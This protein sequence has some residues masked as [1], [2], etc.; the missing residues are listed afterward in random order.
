MPHSDSSSIKD[1]LSSYKMCGSLI[2]FRCPV[3][4]GPPTSDPWSCSWG[5]PL[6][7][8]E[9]GIDSWGQVLLFFGPSPADGPGHFHHDRTLPTGSH[10]S[11]AAPWLDEIFL[12]LYLVSSCQIGGRPTSWSSFFLLLCYFPINLLHLKLI[13][14]PF[15]NLQLT[16][17]PPLICLAPTILHWY[18]SLSVSAFYFR[19]QNSSYSFLYVS[20]LTLWWYKTSIQYI[21]LKLLN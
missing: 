7:M 10:C 4:Q 18:M 3:T 20:N 9:W 12:G 21:F 13:M 15:Q 17:Y 1:S 8:T 19:L 16:L 6:P 11:R 2:A 14:L 5:S